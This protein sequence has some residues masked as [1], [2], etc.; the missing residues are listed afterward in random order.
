MNV[1]R[2]CINNLDID[3]CGSG[4]ICLGMYEVCVNTLGHY[5]CECARYF[6]R[7][8]VSGQCQPD[9]AIYSHLRPP[10]HKPAAPAPDSSSKKEDSGER[11]ET[12]SAVEDSLSED[13][14]KRLIVAV[15]ICIIGTA[16]ASGN[17]IWT[18]LFFLS[19]LCAGIWWASDKSEEI[20]KS[21][22]KRTEL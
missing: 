11:V 3:E 17:L 22:I 12:E 21:F 8:S 1:Y 7:D 14:I 2:H 20:A 16:A 15:L 13:D 19:I 5:K 4:A 18:A 6:R 10:S 9:P